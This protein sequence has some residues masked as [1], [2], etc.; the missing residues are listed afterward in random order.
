[1]A[2][3]SWKSMLAEQIGGQIAKA[4]GIGI[5]RMLATARPAQTGEAKKTEL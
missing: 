4:G 1:M 3:G 5:A 2:G